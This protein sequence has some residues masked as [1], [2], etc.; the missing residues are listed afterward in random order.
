LMA[1]ENGSSK[2]ILN[3]AVQC[4]GNLLIEQKQLKKHVLQI[5]LA[6]SL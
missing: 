1:S 2:E 3:M 4:L 6:R 5:G